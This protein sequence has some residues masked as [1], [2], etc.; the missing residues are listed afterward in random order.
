MLHTVP[1]GRTCISQLRLHRVVGHMLVS[2]A[3]QPVRMLRRCGLRPTPQRIAIIHLIMRRRGQAVTA[4][5]IINDVWTDRADVSRATVCKT[6]REFAQAGLMVR[7]A[8][9]GSRQA[10]YRINPEHFSVLPSEL[11]SPPCR[12]NR[13]PDSATLTL[14]SKVRVR[15]QRRYCGMPTSSTPRRFAALQ[16]SR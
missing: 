9:D 11:P 12:L 8:V 5:D 1:V 10:W 13:C 7:S 2:L 4:R 14:N 15:L 6:L 3:E 16:V